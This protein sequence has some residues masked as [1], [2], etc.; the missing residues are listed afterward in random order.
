MDC[1]PDLL[2]LADVRLHYP[3][4][5]I[6]ALGR[7]VRQPGHLSVAIAAVPLFEAA[8]AGRQSSPLARAPCVKS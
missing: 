6:G 8:P 4:D 3:D 1:S 2:S 7:R 5:R